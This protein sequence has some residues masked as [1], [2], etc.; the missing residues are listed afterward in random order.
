VSW[1][2]NYGAFSKVLYSGYDAAQELLDFPDDLQEDSY[3][4]FVSAL[5]FYMTPQN[6]KPS[7]HEVA[8][9]Y[10]VP[11]YADIH[12]N[13]DEGYEFGATTNI[14]NGGQECGSG[15]EDARSTNRINYY[16]A[17]LTDFGLPAENDNTL[18]C[19]NQGSFGNSGYGHHALYFDTKWWPEGGCKIVNWQTGYSAYTPDDYKRCVCDAWGTDP[20]V[21]CAS[22]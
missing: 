10:M 12:N 20:E 22:E 1:N 8:T 11:T 7:M 4:V 5:W 13:I 6:P 16:K 2:Y 17:L 18:G 21:D 19:K 9:G 14:I 3:T 15:S